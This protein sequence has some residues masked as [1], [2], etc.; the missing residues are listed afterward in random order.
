MVENA[1]KN[2]IVHTNE[3]RI[4]CW[5]MLQLSLLSCMHCMLTVQKRYYV[6]EGENENGKKENICT[7]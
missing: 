2:H 1:N 7:Y 6:N 4:E 5:T 3:T